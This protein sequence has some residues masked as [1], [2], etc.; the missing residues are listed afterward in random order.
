MW[1][2]CVIITSDCLHSHT[3]YT[4]TILNSNVC[5][6]QFSICWCQLKKH[7]TD[8]MKMGMKAVKIHNE[9]KRKECVLIEILSD[10]ETW[11]N[12]LDHH[13]TQM[14]DLLNLGTYLTRGQ[15]LL[16]WTAYACPTWLGS[17]WWWWQWLWRWSMA[18]IVTLRRYT[19]RLFGMRRMESGS[20]KGLLTSLGEFILMSWLADKGVLRSQWK[21]HFGMNLIC[22]WLLWKAIEQE[23]HTPCGMAQAG[24]AC[25]FNV[26]LWW[27]TSMRSVDNTKTGTPRIPPSAKQGI[28]H[29]RQHSQVGRRLSYA[30]SWIMWVGVLL[31]CMMWLYNLSQQ[32]PVQCDW[33][34]EGVHLYIIIDFSLGNK[35]RTL[36]DMLFRQLLLPPWIEYYQLGI[37]IS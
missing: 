11:V 24:R 31:A 1:P 13:M 37:A 36:T 19:L 32:S 29:H 5:S 6:V 12:M 7:A 28:C 17:F 34:V 2:Y 21:L 16:C 14:T 22:L 20:H 8:A 30:C 15:V 25:I 9:L 23:E 26:H 18:Q 27:K 35:Q 10:S 4:I 33:V 3:L